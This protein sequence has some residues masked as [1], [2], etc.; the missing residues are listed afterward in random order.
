MSTTSGVLHTTTGGHVFRI[1][2]EAHGLTLRE[3]ARETSVSASHLSRIES[4]KARWS[5]GSYSRLID[6]YATT[7]ARRT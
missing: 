7:T 5:A 3:V 4:G 2:R 6:F 1:F